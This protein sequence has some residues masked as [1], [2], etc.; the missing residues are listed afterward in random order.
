MTRTLEEHKLHAYI[1][2]LT[3]SAGRKT[4]SLSELQSL[5]GKV[6][7]AI[8]T[9]PPMAACLAANMYTM[10]R[11]TSSTLG[12]SAVPHPRRVRTFG[13]WRSFWT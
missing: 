6:Q 11:T 12:R 9:L 7:R 2:L 3:E 13:T 5:A 8:M 1:E 4:L 10:M